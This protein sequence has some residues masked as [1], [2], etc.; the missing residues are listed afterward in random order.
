[1]FI[2]KIT[3]DRGVS[4]TVLLMFYAVGGSVQPELLFRTQMVV[5]GASFDE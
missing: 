4:A 5:F 3:K 2:N 1:M